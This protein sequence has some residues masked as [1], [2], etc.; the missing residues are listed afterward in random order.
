MVGILFIVCGVWNATNAYR[1][2][3]LYK[4]FLAILCCSAAVFCFV[5]AFQFFFKS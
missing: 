1:C 3:K 2:Y 5:K 4:D